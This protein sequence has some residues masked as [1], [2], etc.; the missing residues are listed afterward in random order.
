MKKLLSIITTIVVIGVGTLIAKDP[1]L[2]AKKQLPK[3]DISQGEPTQEQIAKLRLQA[4]YMK[5]NSEIFK[6]VADYWYGLGWRE[7][8]AGCAKTHRVNKELK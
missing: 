8:W 6:V 5:A 2:L 4:W 1:P 7:G 3:V